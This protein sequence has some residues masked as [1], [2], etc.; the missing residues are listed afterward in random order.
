MQAF[1]QPP[2]GTVK[3]ASGKTYLMGRSTADGRGFPLAGVCWNGK[4]LYL[5][6]GAW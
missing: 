4:D 6:N 3:R 1:C 2:C 5:N